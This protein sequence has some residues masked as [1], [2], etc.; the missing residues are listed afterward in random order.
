M[1]C[2]EIT[3]YEVIKKV[4]VFAPIKIIFNDIILYND[5]DSDVLIEVLEDGAKVYGEIHP[6]LA[7]ISDRIKG[8]EDSI[9]TSLN[10]EIVD[11]HHSIVSMQGGIST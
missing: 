8:F 7:V 4:S 3:L 2:S 5:Y 1:K 9:V 11:F 10:I 6:P